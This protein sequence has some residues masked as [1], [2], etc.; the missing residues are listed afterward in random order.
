MLTNRPSFITPAALILQ[1]SALAAAQDYSEKIWGVFSYT[2]YGDSTPKILASPRAQVLTEYGAS[3]LYTAGSAFRARYVEDGMVNT[4]GTGIQN[5]APNIL[6][7]LEVNAFSTAEP[8]VLASAQA[9]MQGLYPPLGQSL[10]LLYS[11]LTSQLSNGSQSTYPLNGY[12]YPLIVTMDKEDPHSLTLAGQAK[13]PMHHASDN[14]YLHT[15][16][17]FEL[18]EWF[19]P[20]Y[21]NMWEKALSVAYDINA[22]SYPNAVEISEFLEYES[23]HNDTLMEAINVGDI[24]L[25]RWLADQYIWAT[26]SQTSSSSEMQSNVTP[27]AGQTLASSILD[28][29]DANVQS[30]GSQ[31][32]M[33]M[34]FGGDKPA[35]ALASLLGLAAEQQPNFYSRPVRGGSLVFELYSFDDSLVPSYPSSDSLYVRFFLHNGTSNDTAW[36]SYPLFGHGPSRDF[37]PYNEFRQEIETFALS[38]TEDWCNLCQSESVFCKGVLGDKDST[39]KKRMA[40][41]VAGVIGAVV[42]LVAIGLLAVIGLLV[43]SVRFRKR[44]EGAQRSSLGGF[45]GT[46]KLAS[47]TDVTFRH[48]I[49]GTSKAADEHANDEITAGGVVVQGHERLGSWEMGQ[50]S[51]EIENV[52]STGQPQTTSAFDEENDEEWRIHSGLTPVKVRDSI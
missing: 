38:S 23:V 24:A 21:M 45:K 10:D 52:D 48:P 47:D 27:I 44:R 1:V 8:F 36:Q 39:Q 49:W 51:K 29:F 46:S 15:A 33:T 30:Q 14:E 16:E 26:N 42:T 2:L 43:C 17:A 19:A 7:S 13:C 25:A 41:A 35:V 3:A 50:Q 28:A 20:F 32:K 5:I 9:F 31:Q 18:T 40:P 22:A 11:D 37:I 4:A 6:D 12:Q 34:L